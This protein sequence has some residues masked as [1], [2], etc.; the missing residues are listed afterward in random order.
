VAVTQ[1]NLFFYQAFRGK[2]RAV[3]RALRAES[4]GCLRTQVLLGFASKH[5][6]ST[7]PYVSD[8]LGPWPSIVF[9]PGASVRPP[10]RACSSGVHK[11]AGSSRGHAVVIGHLGEALCLG[12]AQGLGQG[13]RQ[14]WSGR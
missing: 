13:L 10:L 11:R 4:G 14:A 7:V 12:G 8:W 1:R 9:A 3:R 2:C 6:V 5:N